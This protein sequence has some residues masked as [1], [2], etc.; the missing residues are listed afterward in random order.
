MR[1]AAA[2]VTAPA[3]ESSSR[4][5]QG[6]RKMKL[7]DTKATMVMVPEPG[8]G[9]GSSG[10]QQQDAG[11]NFADDRVAVSR[12]GR[13]L[14]K[15][16]RRWEQCADDG[17]Q[18]A[19]RHH[20]LPRAL[21]KQ[22]EDSSEVGQS[23]SSAAE[24]SLQ[25]ALRRP[26]RIMARAPR[27]KIPSSSREAGIFSQ[28][29]Y[30]SPI[31]ISELRPSAFQRTLLSKGG[32]STAA[33]GD[34]AGSESAVFAD[35][36]NLDANRESPL[37]W[38]HPPSASPCLQ[39][40]PYLAPSPPDLANTFSLFADPAVGGSLPNLA[41]VVLYSSS[42]SGSLGTELGGSNPYGS[43]NRTEG[44]SACHGP[45]TRRAA[46]GGRLSPAASGDRSVRQLN[47][48]V[49]YEEVEKDAD[50]MYE[51]NDEE[52]WQSFLGPA[53]G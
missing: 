29:S 30:G 41:P 6:K 26:R 24:A 10:A 36:Q 18:P 45:A 8:P 7:T 2:P 13:V 46:A 51:R 50:A 35:T 5:M 33:S 34:A 3:D 40:P 12:Y 23:S 43:L 53:G 14:P 52:A 37:Y 4:L 9:P 17:G 39:L 49:Y 15:R 20:Q 38:P 27:L 47:G 42:P 11:G 1:R 21:G 16:S 48:S 22:W 32:A 19:D 44:N 25:P 28:A 31:V